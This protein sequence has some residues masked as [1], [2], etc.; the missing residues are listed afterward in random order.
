[1]GNELGEATEVLLARC[2]HI[3]ESGPDIA[4]T[5]KIKAAA[6]ALRLHFRDREVT[7]DR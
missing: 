4:E 2:Y 5:P 6:P 1:L 7:I 3:A